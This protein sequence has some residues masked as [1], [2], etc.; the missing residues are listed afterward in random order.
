MGAVNP[1]LRW[2]VLVRLSW[3]SVDQ[4]AFTLPFESDSDGH[5]YVVA[6]SS[7][8]SEASRAAGA[9]VGS[10]QPYLHA[11]ANIGEMNLPLRVFSD[12]ECR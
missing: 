10:A 12:W 1:G 2:R 6:R 9:R 3:V 4:V 8:G 7:M 5:V 11:Q